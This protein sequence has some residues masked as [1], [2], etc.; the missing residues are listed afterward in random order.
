MDIAEVCL[1]AEYLERIVE[2]KPKLGELD[3]CLK[4]FFLH[5][6]FFYLRIIVCLIYYY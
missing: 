5:D 3:F 2:H 6:C 4:E 1:P